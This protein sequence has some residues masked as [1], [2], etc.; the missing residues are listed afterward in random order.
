MAQGH[1]IG[2]AEREQVR[3]G[4]LGA[5]RPLT[6]TAAVLNRHG[7]E[8]DRASST[9]LRLRTCPFL[10]LAARAP[11]MVCGINHAFLADLLDGLDAATVEAVLD[12]QAGECRVE[13][14]VR[15]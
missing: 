15:R 14:R 4:R 12:P 13:L 2:A 10:P 11:E 1:R 3:P 9:C 7:F 6:L 8:P 5:E